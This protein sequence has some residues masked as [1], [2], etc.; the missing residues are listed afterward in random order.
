MNEPLCIVSKEPTNFLLKK[1]GYSFYRCPGC[2]LVF[3]YP[4]P[5]GGEI[6]NLYS[7]ESG[8]QANKKINVAHVQS[9]KKDRTVI[10]YLKS[11][12]PK[13]K[14]LDIGASSGDFLFLAKEEGLETYGVEIN[15]GTGETAQARGLDVFIGSFENIPFL[16]QSFDFIFLGDVIEHVPDPR[17][18]LEKCKNLLSQKGF[19]IISTPNLDSFWARTTSLSE[20]NIFEYYHRSD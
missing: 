3:V 12:N 5:E 15:K 17:I 2:D 10:S 1:D 19:L 13:G 11:K 9:T 8:Y 7:E 18:L 4:V 6:K 16:P 20:E 14:I